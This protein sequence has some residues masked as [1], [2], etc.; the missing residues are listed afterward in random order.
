MGIAEEKPGKE[1][2]LEL[3]LAGLTREDDH[4]GEAKMAKDG[5]PDCKND[6]ALVGTEVDA[7]GGSPTDGIAADGPAD[8][9]S[10]RRRLV[11]SIKHDGRQGKK[12]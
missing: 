2:G 4:K 6:P 8:A 1:V 7:T 10:N 9:E 12:D 11:K 3:V 5:F